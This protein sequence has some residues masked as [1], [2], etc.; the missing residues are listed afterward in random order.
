[1][2][3]EGTTQTGGA[4]PDAVAFRSLIGVL[5]PK[6]DD[7]SVLSAALAAKRSALVKNGGPEFDSAIALWRRTTDSAINE[8]NSRQQDA[9][10]FGAVSGDFSELYELQSRLNQQLDAADAAIQKTLTDLKIDLS[11]QVQDI[12]GRI[13][14][15]IPDHLEQQPQTS[16][17]APG[18]H[19][20][21]TSLLVPRVAAT[22]IWSFNNGNYTETEDVSADST[23]VYLTTSFVGYTTNPNMTCTWD[24]YHQMWQ[25]PGCSQCGNGLPCHSPSISAY[26][27]G[28]GGT[29]SYGSAPPSYYWNIRKAVAKNAINPTLP[30]QQTQ[31]NVNVFCTGANGYIVS[32]TL[33]ALDLSYIN[34]ASEISSYLG[35]DPYG[36]VCLT[37][38]TRCNNTP[39]A[40]SGT[41]AIAGANSSQYCSSLKQYSA[42]SHM[43]CSKPQSQSTW[44]SSNCLG[45]QIADTIYNSPMAP[46]TCDTYP[47]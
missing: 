26:I 46:I 33:G 38:M 34:L 23:Y 13:I 16:N 31:S 5:A 27:G 7:D 37:G 21:N 9:A 28:T 10:S 29:S 39:F 25:P 4:V 18:G 19:L 42:T 45:P 35:P 8:Y 41:I 12:K 15:H 20:L 32:D 43:V 30:P 24:S 14:H 3:Y 36:S 44:S 6:D 22:T 40:T 47:H 2:P 17:G 1:M 11:S